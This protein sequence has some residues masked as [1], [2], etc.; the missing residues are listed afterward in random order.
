MGPPEPDPWQ[1]P[2]RGTYRNRTLRSVLGICR[3]YAKDPFAWW[4]TLTAAQQAILLVDYEL[5]NQEGRD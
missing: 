2:M 1:A 5:S 4:D 3:A